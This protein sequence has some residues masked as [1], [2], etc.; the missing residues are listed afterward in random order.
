M[1]SNWPL[2]ISVLLILLKQVLKLYLN[3]KPDKVDYIKA[4]ASLPVDVI[5]LVIGLCAKAAMQPSISSEVIIGFIFA[6]FIIS[7]F[8]TLLWRTCEKEATTGAYYH[9]FW[10]LPFNAA[11]TFTVFIVALQYVG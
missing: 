7:I 6:Y 9:S 3:H 5:F 8:S 2:V 1:L 4:L 10:A 11:M